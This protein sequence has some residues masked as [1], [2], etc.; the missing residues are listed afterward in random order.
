MFRQ[1]SIQKKE[2]RLL[3]IDDKILLTVVAVQSIT[4]TMKKLLRY[5]LNLLGLEV[6]MIANFHAP[7][8]EI[9]T[10]GYDR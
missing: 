7:A 2:T 3:I 8:L 1:H 9:E 6:G 10:V 4:F 5:Y